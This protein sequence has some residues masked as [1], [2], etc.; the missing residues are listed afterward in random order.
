MP[1]KNLTA[2]LTR[3]VRQ[4]L[5]GRCGGVAGFCGAR[6]GPDF[7][8]LAARLQA[9]SSSLESGLEM[10]AHPNVDSVQHYRSKYI[11]VCSHRHHNIHHHN[12][13]Y[14][15]HTILSSSGSD[16]ETRPYEQDPSILFSDWDLFIRGA[17]GKFQDCAYKN[18]YTYLR[19]FVGTVL[20]FQ[21]H[22]ALCKAA[23]QF[24]PEYPNTKPLFKCD[25][26]RSKEAGKLL[27]LNTNVAFGGL[28]VGVLTGP[29]INFVNVPSKSVTSR[30]AQT[31]TGGHRD[32]MSL[33]SSVPWT[34]A[35]YKATGETRLNGSHIREYF[36]PL[37]DW[38][39][40][41]NLRTNEYVGWTY[42][43]ILA[44]W[45]EGK[46]K[47]ERNDDRMEFRRRELRYLFRSD[48]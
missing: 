42:V 44:V 24:D 36:R 26:Y 31:S 39:R 34:E 22:S 1:E 8:R 38:L 33:G 47:K 13:H 32:M 7:F 12:H 28:V 25:I 14:L 6:I 17:I 19:H 43:T 41:E 48:E 27:N 30:P 15:D 37:E 21:L 20:Q 9:Q 46:S 23:G 10:L 35:L 40:N 45:K 11:E 29:K 3:T 18:P 4:W 2:T 16:F 5:V